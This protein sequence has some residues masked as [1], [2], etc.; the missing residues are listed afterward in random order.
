MTTLIDRTPLDPKVIPVP[1][2]PYI[3][4]MILIIGDSGAGKTRFVG[5]F[6]RPYIID[7]DKGT[8]SVPG[9]IAH[10]T[11]VEM[12]RPSAKA[13][14][15]TYA[16]G[17]GWAAVM[18]HVDEIG[19]RMDKGD[20]P[21][22]T[23]AFDS[24]TTLQEMALNAVLKTAAAGSRYKVGDSVDPGLWGAQMNL[25]QGLV[26]EVRMWPGIKVFTAHIQKDTNTVTEA[27]EK[28]ALVTGKLAGKLPIYFDEIYFAETKVVPISPANPVGRE[29][30]LRTYSDAVHKAARSRLEV[31]M[32]TGQDFKLIWPY[33]VKR[34]NERLKDPTWEGD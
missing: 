26:G 24:L 34:I 25:I 3:K 8:E 18:K 2:P 30:T 1:L 28:M 9:P 14:H 13:R 17:E 4:R 33:L 32:N 12:N 31:P 22:D 6:P 5:T 21:H 11:F 20:W 23:L 15:G 16:Y 10:K 7:S 29:Y 19:A 27:I